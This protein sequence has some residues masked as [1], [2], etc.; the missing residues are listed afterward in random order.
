MAKDVIS[1]AF[2]EISEVDVDLVACQ[3]RSTLSTKLLVGFALT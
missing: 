2:A 1:K 3:I